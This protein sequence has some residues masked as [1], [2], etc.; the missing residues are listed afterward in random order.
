MR[1]A[2]FPYNE[3]LIL[4]FRETTDS[5]LV[6]PDLPRRSNATSL[7]SEIP[8]PEAFN[9]PKSRCRTMIMILPRSDNLTRDEQSC[10]LGSSTCRRCPRIVRRTVDALPIC[11]FSAWAIVPELGG[12]TWQIG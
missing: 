3:Y 12:E 9:P 2:A 4:P 1:E 7:D 8:L 11:H 10:S 6:L 5:R